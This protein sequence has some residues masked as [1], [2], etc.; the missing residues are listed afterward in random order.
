[1]TQSVLFG[2]G[3]GSAV[4]GGGGRYRYLLQR[5][6]GTGNR[7]ALYVM[8]NPSTAD[9]EKDDPTVRRCIMRAQALG[10]DGIEVCN[11]FAFRAT[12]PRQMMA[13]QIDPV[14]PKNDVY[15]RA[16]ART[17]KLII[18]AWGAHGSYLSRDRAVLA[19]LPRPVYCLGRTA[20]GLPKHPLYIS[21]AQKLV[22]FEQR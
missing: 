8:L 14:G 16:A 1:M 6:W 5:R 20:G 2:F 4:F 19:L 10:Y 15:I 22:E 18:V 7:F 3:A 17:A 13:S 12:D 21:N 9:E 11:L